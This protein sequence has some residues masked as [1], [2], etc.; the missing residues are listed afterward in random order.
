MK[1]VTNK[2]LIA[3]TFIA[4]LFAACT[5]PDDVENPQPV[6]QELITTVQLHVTG[7]SGF[8][9]TFSYK[10]ENGFGSTTQGNVSIDSIILA[11]GTIYD[12]EV[13]VLN[14]K[15]SPAEDITEEVLEEKDEHLFLFVSAPSSGAGSITT[16]NGSKDNNNKPFNQVVEFHT[17][18]N[19][20]GALTVTLK[21]EPTNKDV[22]DPAAAG[23][24]TDAEAVFPVLIR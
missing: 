14:E 13:K 5:K 20:T 6:E 12:V 9:K 10:V 4:L 15:E 7:D 16:Q 11:P 2:I 24:E 23:G 22:T 3:F 8:D 17:G 21:H 18:S 1:N 19:G